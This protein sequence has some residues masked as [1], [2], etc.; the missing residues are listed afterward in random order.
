MLHV[1]CSNVED[2]REAQEGKE[3]NQSASQIWQGEQKKYKIGSQSYNIKKVKPLLQA[4]T[5]NH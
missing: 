4:R 3:I 5:R 2:D 1:E